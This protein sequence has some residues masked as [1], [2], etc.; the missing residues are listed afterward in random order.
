MDI[1]SIPAASQAP[2]TSS[3]SS[4]GT[5]GT[6][7]PSMP[8]SAHLFANRSVPYATNIKEMIDHVKKASDIPCAIGFGIATPEQAHDMASVSD[9]AIVGSAIV[10]LIAQNGKNCIDPV[11]QYV[12]EMK[13]AVASA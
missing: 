2:F 6:M 13:A 11:C 1:S 5:S 9:G 8:H 7:I 10:R 3:F 12:R 4:N